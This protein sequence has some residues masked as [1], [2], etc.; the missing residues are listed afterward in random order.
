M[1]IYDR[2]KEHLCTSDTGIA[3][4]RRMLLEVA[5]AFRESGKKPE[6][7]SDPDLY[8]VRAVSLKL[9]KDQAWADAGADPMTARL[10]EGLGYEL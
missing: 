2:T 3:M 9:P 7:F 1:R 10:G 8:L 6:R 5:H 4:T